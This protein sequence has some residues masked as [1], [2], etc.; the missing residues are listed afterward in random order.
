MARLTPSGHAGIKP[1]AS[2][3]NNKEPAMTQGSNDTILNWDD[4]RRTEADVRWRLEALKTGSPP[5]ADEEKQLDGLLKAYGELLAWRDVGF[6]LLMREGKPYLFDPPPVAAYLLPPQDSAE[7]RWLLAFFVLPDGQAAVQVLAWSADD[8]QGA[9]LRPLGNTPP[10]PIDCKHR[11]D[12]APMDLRHTRFGDTGMIHA[13]FRQGVLDLL[14]D[15]HRGATTCTWKETAV[16]NYV[17]IQRSSWGAMPVI[18]RLKRYGPAISWR[19]DAICDGQDKKP[20]TEG[21]LGRI[22]GA[23]SPASA[24]ELLY[25]AS[26][27]GRVYRLG[28][29]NAFAK[30]E[31]MTD[32]VLD[33]LAVP[34]FDGVGHAVLAVVREGAVY[35]LREAGGNRLAA[36]YWQFNHSHIWRMIGRG[37]RH[38]LSLDERGEL[39]PLRLYDPDRFHALRRD[40]TDELMQRVFFRDGAWR[41]PEEAQ[42]R[43]G[44][45]SDEGRDELL[46]W[47]C[48]A[49]EYFFHHLDDPAYVEAFALW[50]WRLN[51]L[52]PELADKR[53]C[54]RL[55][56]L[57]RRWLRRAL[58]WIINSCY[59]GRKAVFPS[60]GNAVHPVLEVI[61][62]LLTPHREAPDDIW[63]MLLRRKD[64]LAL[65]AQKTHLLEQAPVAERLRDF[66]LAIREC[67]LQILPGLNEIRPLNTLGSRRF[68][69]PLNHLDI[70]DKDQK[71]LAVLESRGGL[72]LIQVPKEVS[73][74]WKELGK[75]GHGA[76]WH[77]QPS[78]VR[79]LP[80]KEAG[81]GYRLLVGTMRGE[82]VLLEW[83]GENPRIIKLDEKEDCGFA[84][85]CSHYLS[86]HHYLVLGGRNDEGRACLYGL[87]EGDKL[88]SLKELWVDQKTSNY[89]TLRM[90][91]GSEDGNILWGI[92]RDR[93]QLL[94]W[95]LEPLHF[96]RGRFGSP[97]LWHSSSLKLHCLDFSPQQRLLVC[98]GEGGMTWALDSQDGTTR[99]AVQCAGNLRHVRY[100]ER[101]GN[102][103]EGIWLLA[104]D[105]RSSLLADGEGRVRGVIE[106]AGPASALHVCGN[107]LLLATLSGR[108]LRMGYHDF[109]KAGFDYTG[110]P[111]K[112]ALYPLRLSPEWRSEAELLERLDADGIMESLPAMKLLVQTAAFLAANPVSDDLACAVK[113]FFF[114][115]RQTLERC[116]LFLYRLRALCCDERSE[117]PLGNAC[118]VRFTLNLLDECW[119]WLL[120]EPPGNA[121]GLLCKVVSPLLDILD[122]LAKGEQVGDEAHRLRATLRAALWQGQDCPPVLVKPAGDLSAIRL[123]QARKRW[124]RPPR[125]ADSPRQL[126]DW[127]N[128]VADEAGVGDAEPLRTCLQYLSE[129]QL[130]LLPRQDAWW[131]W[132]EQLANGAPNVPSPPA[133]LS[134]LMEPRLDNLA[135]Q[136]L[137]KLA[138]LFGDN[139]VWHA[140][141]QNLRGILTSLQATSHDEAHWANREHGDWLRLREHV[142]GAGGDRFTVARG[143]SLLALLWPALAGN[144]AAFI[145]QSLQSLEDKIFV[146]PERYVLLNIRDRWW[147]DRSVELEIGFENRFRGLLELRSLSW[148]AEPLAV[149]GLPLF[150]PTGENCARHLLVLEADDNRLQGELRLDCK[151]VETGKK[152]EVPKVLTI[153]RGVSRLSSAPAWEASWQRLL[154][155]LEDYAKNR[156]GFAWID[157]T[158]WTA[159]ERTRLKEDVDY[160][161][162]FKPSGRGKGLAENAPLFSPDLA[163]DA[164]AEE[165]LGQL[166]GLLPNLAKYF[167]KPA[168]STIGRGGLWALALW[169]LARGL[170]PGIEKVLH[171]YLPPEDAVRQALQSLL[172][173]WEPD[174]QAE[175]SARAQRLLDALRALPARALGAWCA[176]EPFYAA[177]ARERL[178]PDELYLPSAMLLDE[179]LWDFLDQVPAVPVADLAVFF[180]IPPDLAERQRQTRANLRQLKTAMFSADMPDTRQC[181]VLAQTLLRHLG[182][183]SVSYDPDKVWRLETSGTPLTLNWND[184]PRCW[185]VPKRSAV[186]LARLANKPEGLWL[187]LG[188]AS[189]PNNLPGFALGL[190]PKDFLALC[191][192]ERPED[193]LLWLNKLVAVQH[194]V[195]ASQTFRVNG[196]LAHLVGKHFTGRTQELQVLKNCLK[197]VDTKLSEGG[198]QN[199]EAALLIGGR[200]MGKTSLRQRVQYDLDRESL[201]RRVWVDLNFEGVPGQLHGV[202]L[203]RWFMLALSEAY[204]KTSFAF[205]ITWSDQYKDSYARRDEI[206]QRLREH[207]LRIKTKTDRTPLWTFDET[208]LLA[209]ADSQHEKTRW[210]LFRL[211]RQLLAEGLICLFATSYPH[212]ADEPAAL[213]VANHESG[214]PIHN[215]FTQELRLEAWTPRESWEYLHSRLAGLGVL[216]PRHYREEMLAIS[217]G[218]PWLVHAFGRALCEALP[219]GSAS[220]I[221]DAAVWAR[222]RKRVLRDLNEALKVPVDAAAKRRDEALG[223]SPE[224]Q[225]EAALQGNLWRVLCDSARVPAL[226]RRFSDDAWPDND[227]R[228][229]V[230]QLQERLPEVNREALRTALCE[231]SASPTLEGKASEAGVYRF[232]HDL[233]PTWLYYSQISGVEG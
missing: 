37:D 191:H 65:W 186:D 111:G 85:V 33:V 131:Q 137:N 215:T 54:L 142:L 225:P 164:D 80:N 213:N 30:S 17:W 136:W 41:L 180:G 6:P 133:P 212:G 196:G 81:K 90:L 208:E 217:R 140:W 26:N 126:F 86:Q 73:G 68:L 43:E 22:R 46:V 154:F 205:V 216:L 147:G 23:D 161:Y 187:C 39:L 66:K 55:A 143:Q 101:Y 75:L 91:R 61:F 34:D 221:V 231:L 177:H 141:L 97:E 128:A 207:L 233:L 74:E 13:E 232:A 92:N 159:E 7:E 156:H 153:E 175:A 198:N 199:W 58:R 95:R 15:A 193:A 178:E 163:L 49:L 47:V 18:A 168:S 98:G 134:R 89:S 183:G 204:K 184:Y 57:H 135:G 16:Q 112:A 123:N 56:Y 222:A 115:P 188:E 145:D 94:A 169:R 99:W 167:G 139:P 70:L 120:R 63:F 224:T 170:P 171:P 122:A 21:K 201:P 114:D 129:A 151:E 227:K 130:R 87:A 28:E 35:F 185:L 60:A 202:E 190:F 100:L 69:S 83:D 14:V 108:L 76:Y 200:R 5:E 174:G 118:F 127:C 93:G 226:P 44:L 2:S 119:Q 53:Q 79:C 209:R 84:I 9:T 52:Y 150:M 152:L 146:H 189:P 194:G 158:V 179:A 82:L 165:Q 121:N 173:P 10:H 62:N 11:F 166:H 157:G 27:R 8:T 64:W 148:Q 96:K 149:A 4:Y 106:Q 71:W 230:G 32:E 78:F 211:F 160:K 103:K 176:K 220:K 132:L 72:R 116:I 77:G 203:E 210:A 24:P 88:D 162:E 206:R 38:V 36:P 45:G 110:G 104:G 219:R 223:I 1:L 19:D 155:L 29:Q 42:I 144:W 124:D 181:E 172:S 218:V 138:D 113:G 192:A 109:A 48:L 12:L 105:D 214:S 3:R 125:G 31:I 59:H 40:A 117:L 195:D 20:L 182:Q 67:R 51:E 229:S 197:A 107:E 50:Q 25:L 228:V 102:G